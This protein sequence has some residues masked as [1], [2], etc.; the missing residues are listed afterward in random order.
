[1]T[2]DYGPDSQPRRR[3]ELAVWFNDRATKRRGFDP[4]EVY[5]EFVDQQLGSSPSLPSRSPAQT[6]SAKNSI[7]IV[8]VVEYNHIAL[9]NLFSTRR[10]GI[11]SVSTPRVRQL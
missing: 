7:G 8:E 6:P 1:M 4:D 10:G 3:Q 2:I 5:E 11:L 9:P